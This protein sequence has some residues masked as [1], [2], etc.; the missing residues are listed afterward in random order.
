MQ[1]NSWLGLK[2]TG[3]VSI[4]LVFSITASVNTCTQSSHVSKSF[5]TIPLAAFSSSSSAESQLIRSS[6]TIPED[7]E[8]SSSDWLKGE[9][10]FSQI[11]NFFK[12]LVSRVCHDFDKEMYGSEDSFVTSAKA[13]TAPSPEY[14]SAWCKSN[15]LRR[16]QTYFSL[17]SS[18]R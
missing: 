9:C 2:T 1:W 17:G 4:K 13:S 7:R 3:Y 12:S 5:S 16:H 15:A 11:K 10:C 14:F 8:M 18:H 6:A